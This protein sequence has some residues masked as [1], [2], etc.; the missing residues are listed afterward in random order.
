[1]WWPF[2]NGPALKTEPEFT[3]VDPA[4]HASASPVITIDKI[5]RQR[6]IGNERLKYSRSMR[7]ESDFVDRLRAMA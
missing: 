2:D 6:G 1:M 5:R 3:A 4:T 7:C